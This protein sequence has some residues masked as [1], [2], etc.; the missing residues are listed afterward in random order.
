MEGIVQKKWGG[1]K[2]TLDEKALSRGIA[3]PGIAFPTLG[4]GFAIKK[5]KKKERI[6]AG[7]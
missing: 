5:K 1:W 7:R 6:E 4:V 2:R 3:S